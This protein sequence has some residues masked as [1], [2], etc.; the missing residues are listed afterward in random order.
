MRIDGGLDQAS[1]TGDNEKCS[2]SGVNLHCE[3]EF[4]TT[5]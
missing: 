4:Y 3:S 1:S 5:D 2:D